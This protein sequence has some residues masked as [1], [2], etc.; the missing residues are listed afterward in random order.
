MEATVELNFIGEA[1]AVKELGGTLVKSLDSVDVKCLPQNLISH[2][3]V[4]LSVLKTFADSIDVAG[5]NIPST[6]TI[7]AD[8]SMMVATVA[9]PVTEEEFKKLEE[10][11]VAP[12]LET[13][14]VEE[15]GK[16]E[17]DA[18]AAPEAK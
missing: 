12:S 5:L 6:V 14:A 3:D 18:E 11:S 17:E 8:M 7:L 2:I 4:D 10:A 9:A 16:K 13:I 15:K 1:P